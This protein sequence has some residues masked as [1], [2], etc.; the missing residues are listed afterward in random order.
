MANQPETEWFLGPDINVTAVIKAAQAEAN[1][2]VI[3]KIHSHYK[4]AGWC[5]ESC[6]V[7]KAELTEPERPGTAAN[8]A[9]G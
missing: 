1:R 5:N 8:G 7:L 4:D 3:V 2:G 9:M 6:R